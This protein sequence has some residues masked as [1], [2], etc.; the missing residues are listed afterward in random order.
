M[1]TKTTKKTTTK[2]TP[3]AKKPTAKLKV[4][5]KPTVKPVKDV[6]LVVTTDKKGVFFGYGK[7]TTETTIE[8]KQC[9]MAVYWPEEV[10]GM[11][12]L[13]A[14]GP[15]AKARITKA[16]PSVIL[17]GVTAVFEC[18]KDATEAWE[19]GPWS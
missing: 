4:A 1:A 15:S 3:K 13:A 18:S 5:R 12:G 14:T 19:K 9:R 17:Q 7:K 11:P 8:L 10:K 6:A 16:V 2:V